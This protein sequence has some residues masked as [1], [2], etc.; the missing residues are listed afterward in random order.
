MRSDGVVNFGCRFDGDVEK[1]A[2]MD[3]RE[4]HGVNIGVLAD[5]AHVEPSIIYSMLL[6]RP[7]QRFEAVRVL[8]GFSRLVGVRY[9]LDDVEMMLSKE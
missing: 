1:P 9:V 5:S 6:V 8:E 4:W 2:M 3:L 7:I